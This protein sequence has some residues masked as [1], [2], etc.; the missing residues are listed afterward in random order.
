LQNANSAVTNEDNYIDNKAK[1]EG[2][3]IPLESDLA[4]KVMYAPEGLPNAID[5]AVKDNFK[6]DDGSYSDKVGKMIGG[7]NPIG[8]IRD[9]IANGKDVIDGKK[10]AVVGLGE[11]IIG[12]APIVGDGAKI[13]IKAEKEVIQEG[14]ESLVKRKCLI[15]S[16]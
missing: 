3:E 16:E 8:D 15:K 12:T 1:A 2:R 13:L 6:D 4:R 10:G 7:L 9:I 14:L 11:A 5:S